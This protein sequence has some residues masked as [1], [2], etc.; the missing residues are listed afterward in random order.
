MSC[1]P[2][3]PCGTRTRE[4]LDHIHT[5]KAPRSCDG[6]LLSPPKK[7]PTLPLRMRKTLGFI[8]VN[9]PFYGRRDS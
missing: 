7:P 6:H 2:D 5:L 3:I 8:L 4:G 1:P 9:S